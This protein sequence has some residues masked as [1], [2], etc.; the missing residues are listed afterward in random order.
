MKKLLCKIFG[1]KEGKAKCI[2]EY[3]ILVRRNNNM[4]RV[5]NVSSFS[6]TCERCGK[7]INI[8]DDK[9]AQEEIIERIRRAL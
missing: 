1:H 2:N 5:L 9:E 8:F 3:E 7:I 6:T 4:G